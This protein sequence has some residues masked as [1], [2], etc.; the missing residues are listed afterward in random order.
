[1]LSL[2][3]TGRL[4]AGQDRHRLARLADATHRLAGGV[5]SATVSVAL[6]SAAAMRRLNRER[7]G[8]DH[9][10]DVLSFAYDE[11]RGFMVPSE[12]GPRPL[13]DIFICLEQVRR[14]AKAIERPVATEF[15]LMIVHGILHLLGFDH[16]TDAQ[17]KKM[18]RLQQDIL[19]ETKYL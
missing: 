6:I 9:V 13:G 7:H 4:P 2:E 15:A 12:A 18:F 5:G 14:Q 17:E 1:M 10:T 8:E 3:I 11:A 19:I 16:M